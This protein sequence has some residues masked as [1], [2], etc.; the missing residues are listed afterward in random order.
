MGI[1]FYCP[2]GHKLNVKSFLAGK[3]GY[4]PHC[5]ARVEIPL[6]STRQSSRIGKASPGSAHKE[7]LD[8][9]P[10]AEVVTLPRPE[11][12]LPVARLVLPP[13]A[14]GPQAA[15]TQTPSP[16][17]AATQPAASQPATGQPVAAQPVAGQPVAGQP[18]V[19]Q[20]AA[21]QPV[22]AQ[23]VAGQPGE[24]AS[25]PA[26]GA[27]ER[28]AVAGPDPIA[29]A[30][31]AVWY[32]RPAAGGQ[33]GPAAADVMRQWLDECR[34]AADSLVWRE[35]WPEWRSAAETFPEFTG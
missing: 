28:S 27:V 7:P 29:E 32:V 33:Y 23:P 10:L 31:R 35:G 13:T 19:A 20:P 21:G 17:A 11:R 3:T 22:A 14:D 30:P 25:V 18:V 34:V 6:E 24:V 9:V 8:D 15:A 2:Q 12:D 26:A 1:R 16:A 4:C 5:N